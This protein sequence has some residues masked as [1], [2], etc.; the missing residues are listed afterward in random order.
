MQREGVDFA[1]ALADAQ[2]LGYAERDPSGDIDGWDT[3][4]KVTLIAAVAFGA[5]PS[6]DEMPVMGIGNIRTED[7]QAFKRRNLVCRLIGETAK[8]EAGVTACVRRCCFVP[9]ARRAPCSETTTC[10]GIRA[11]RAGFSG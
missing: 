2:A 9:Q 3:A 8:T 4:R 7:V 11:S 10:A 5:L 1:S 6:E